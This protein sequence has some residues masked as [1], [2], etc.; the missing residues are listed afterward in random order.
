MDELNETHA[1]SGDSLTELVANLKRNI[2]LRGDLPHVSVEKQLEILEDLS[3]FPL[4]QF[5]LARKGANGFW[6]DYIINYPNEAY[7]QA[8]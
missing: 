1:D 4:G 5:F 2:L 3:S 8:L 7:L 6:T